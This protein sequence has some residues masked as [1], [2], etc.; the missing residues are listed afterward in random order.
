MKK[1]SLVLLIFLFIFST[2]TSFADAKVPMKYGSGKVEI[3]EEDGIPVYTWEANEKQLEKM[4][5]LEGKGMSYGEVLKAVA[6]Q[7]FAKMPN[8]NNLMKTPFDQNARE[9]KE[10]D[11]IKMLR[12]Y[13]SSC[14]IDYSLSRYEI[15]LDLEMK[16]NGET[17]WIE[18]LS[19]LYDANTRKIVSARVSTKGDESSSRMFRS[20]SM[21][22]VISPSDG[23]YYG[24]GQFRVYSPADGHYKC[25]NSLTRKFSFDKK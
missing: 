20:H 3:T 12:R 19:R 6:P 13:G 10:F 1:T 11:I 4:N 9:V 8:K 5:E 23:T 24:W 25:E 2:V 7:E 14:D 15:T 22:H 18:I 17:N 21:T 16:T